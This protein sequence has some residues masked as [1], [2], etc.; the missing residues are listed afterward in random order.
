M[1][2]ESV[3]HG[4]ETALGRRRVPIKLGSGDGPVL[5]RRRARAGAQGEAAGTLES[6]RVGGGF[7]VLRLEQHRRRS[8]SFGCGKKHALDRCAGKVRFQLETGK[9]GSRRISLL[10]EEKV[11]HV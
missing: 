2:E 8:T 7:R 11:N 10:D 6:F 5:R 4:T 1:H 9:V 3:R